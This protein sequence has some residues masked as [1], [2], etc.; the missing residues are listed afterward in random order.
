MGVEVN[1]KTVLELYQRWYTMSQNLDETPTQW[2]VGHARAYAYAANDLYMWSAGEERKMIDAW[3][4]EQQP[5][6]TGE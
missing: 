4:S 6:A 2:M 5:R 1:S 3:L